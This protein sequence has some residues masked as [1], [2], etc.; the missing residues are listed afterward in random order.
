M[1]DQ[2]TG[3]DAP[4]NDSHDRREVTS[5]QLASAVW[6][7]RGAGG[8][9]VGARDNRL[10]VASE[11]YADPAVPTPAEYDGIDTRTPEANLATRSNIVS[12]GPG[13]VGHVGS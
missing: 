3:T 2:S 9:T 10:L 12:D 13:T 6:R 4:L 8:E 11:P 1:S 7:V 5:E